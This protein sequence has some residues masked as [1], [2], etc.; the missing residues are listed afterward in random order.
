MFAS[1]SLARRIEHA[2]AGLI[3]QIARAADR[4]V[5]AGQTFLHELNGGV[6]TRA[7]SY[8]ILFRPAD[9]DQSRPAGTLVVTA[10][11]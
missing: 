9:G 7:G 10:E 6:G 3:V 4:R 11:E 1:A 2:D 8:E 5:P